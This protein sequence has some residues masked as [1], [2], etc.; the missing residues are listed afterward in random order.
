VEQS[1]NEVGNKRNDAQF[2]IH[3]AQNHWYIACRSTDLTNEPLQVKIWDTPYVL[4]RNE[5][6][7]ACAL[8]DRCPHRSVPLSIGNCE[9]GKIR[10]GYH[11]WLFDGDGQCVEIPALVDDSP[12]PTIKAGVRPVIEQQGYVWI[13]PGEEEPATQPF[14]FAQLRSDKFVSIRYETDFEA[15]LYCTAENILDVPHTNVLHK[16]LFRK[17]SRRRL[18]V[19]VKRYSDRVICEYQNEP[20]PSG[21]VAKLLTRGAKRV[22]H[23]DRFILPSVAEVEYSLDTGETLVTTSFLTPIS[24][25]QT[26]MNTVVSLSKSIWTSMMGVAVRPMIMKIVK[27]DADILKQ[28]TQ[29]TKHFNEERF[30]HSKV[31]FLGPSIQLL[32][33]RA[34]QAQIARLSDIQAEEPELVRNESLM[35]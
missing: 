10:C 3:R 31:D 11:G 27:Q 23:F 12:L 13:F 9:G 24:D 14:D 16:G 33:K 25:F 32:L 17:D 30:V 8:L 1:M 5:Q 19:E 2:S 26:R 34:A 22:F 7:E 4:F 21:I 20:T 6:G 15:T 35:A 18:E 28:L 29:T